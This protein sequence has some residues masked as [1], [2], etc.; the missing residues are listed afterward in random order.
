M[1]I[2]VLCMLGVSIVYIPIMLANLVYPTNG[3][4][5]VMM[6]GHKGEHQ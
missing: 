1:R 2:S 6:V 5:K 3:P 4:I